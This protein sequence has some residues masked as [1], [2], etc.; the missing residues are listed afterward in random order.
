MTNKFLKLKQVGEKDEL[1]HYTKGTS[2]MNIL[3][4]Q[5]IFATKSSFLND[6]NEMDYILHVARDVIEELP[7]L[8][9]Q[10]LL[11]E[12]VVDTMEEFKRHDTFVLSFSTDRDSITLWSEFGEQTGYNIAFN[13]RKLIERIDRNQEIYCHGEVIYSGEQQHEMVRRLL[14]KK[15]PEKIGASFEEIME[16]AV[17]EK[18]AGAFTEL[19]RRFQKN[20]NAYAMFFKQEEFTPE[21]EYRIVF[22]NPDRSKILFREK[23][24]FLLPYIEIDLSGGKEMPLTSVTV[25]PKNHVDLA[26]KGM[27]Q[28]LELL[29]YRVPVELSRLKLRY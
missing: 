18:N 1:F 10:H 28:Y 7:D 25:A 11:M 22:R 21:K 6:T 16:E 23:E 12:K 9:W 15:L 5:K 13:G 27:N 2:V 20:L 24:G 14:T 19:C 17:K 26:R 4:T 3:K 8:E 29:G